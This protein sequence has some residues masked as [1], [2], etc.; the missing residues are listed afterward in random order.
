MAVMFTL[1]AVPTIVIVLC[2]L[3][4][5]KLILRSMEENITAPP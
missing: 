3:N 4:T 1:V 2:K 5:T